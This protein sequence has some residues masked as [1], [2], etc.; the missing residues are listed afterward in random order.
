MLYMIAERYV[1]RIRLPFSLRGLLLFTLLVSVCLMPL[2]VR[3]YR[4]RCERL[5]TAAIRAVR[6]GFVYDW[7]LGPNTGVRIVSQFARPYGPAW[8]RGLCGDDFFGEV[9]CVDLS[10]GERA[11]I[12]DALLAKLE[13]STGLDTLSLGNANV[14]DA[15]LVHLRPFVI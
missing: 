15:G 7:Q 13:P 2:S 11:N 14:T 4:K 9:V 8:A 5:A 12:T 6:G 10:Y 1:R 3:L